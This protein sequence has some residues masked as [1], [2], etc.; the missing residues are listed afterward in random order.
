MKDKWA[1][2]L[3]KRFSGRKDLG[4]IGLYEEYYKQNGF[5]LKDVLSLFE[6]IEASYNIPVGVLRPDD[7]ISKLTTRIPAKSLFQWLYWLGR[8]EFSDDGWRIELNFRLRKFGTFDCWKTIE[9]FN[10]LVF[11]WC[12]KMPQ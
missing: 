6:E 5:D 3:L 7:E 4:K 9:T 12:G 10:D 2:K 11:A 1:D 8:N